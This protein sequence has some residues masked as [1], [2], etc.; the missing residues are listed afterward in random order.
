L[1]P[2]D[3]GYPEEIV[4]L[5]DHIRSHRMNLG[6]LQR[7]AAVQIGVTKGTVMNW[8]RNR[9]EPETR[10]VPS[11]IE[12]LGYCQYRPV[13]SFGEWLRQCRTTWGLSQET[14]AQ[15]ITVDETTIAKW[16]RG[17]HQPTEKSIERVRE[18]F[19]QTYLDR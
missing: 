8:E 6:L 4:T 15:A 7:E 18:F 9:A 19:L 3:N 11:I 16:E 17:E 2:N 12:F 10:H 1:K 14:L 13:T 5:G